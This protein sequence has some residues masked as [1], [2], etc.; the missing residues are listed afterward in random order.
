MSQDS[1]QIENY[2]IKNNKKDFLSFSEK[3]KL[4]DY[5]QINN[6]E[7]ENFFNFQSKDNK[8]IL[9]NFSLSKSLKEENNKK[10]LNEILYYKNYLFELEYSN[11]SFVIETKILFKSNE[12]KIYKE[13]HLILI[14]QLLII[15]K[16]NKNEEQNDISFRSNYKLKENE[17]R[18]ENK[19][20]YNIKEYKELYDIYHPIFFLNFDLISVKLTTNEK[21]NKIYIQILSKKN[22]IIKL[23]ILNEEIYKKLIIILNINI[24]QSKGYKSNLL[25]ISLNKNFYLN[26]YIN[27]MD[28][29]KKVNTG[30]LLLFKG[31]NYSSKI[32][33]CFTRDKYDHVGII[34]KKNNNICI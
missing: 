31:N 9:E 34:H 21:E 5:I 30:D 19:N 29:E 27:L 24:K 6:K 1:F 23:K 14:K 2:L 12:S 20:K 17:L 16:Y 33:R 8:E 3:S 7:K 18:N 26:Y 13:Y 15:L 25:S 11:L 10:K 22:I 32:Q 28:F 4:D